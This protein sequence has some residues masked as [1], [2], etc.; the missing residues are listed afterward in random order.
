MAQSKRITLRR[1]IYLNIYAYLLLIMGIGIV[2]IPLYE[3]F[4]PLLIIQ[5]I[6]ASQLLKAAIRIFRQWPQKRRSY[7]L[8]MRQNRK[9]FRPET[10]KK[11]MKAPCGRILV[12]TVLSDLDE[13]Q[14]YKELKKRYSIPLSHYLRRTTVSIKPQSTII[15]ING[16]AMELHREKSHKKQTEGE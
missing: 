15:R 12:K 1:Y 7:Y 6:I 9:E 11:H 2:F 13:N 4:K 5:I 14:R 8:L 3:I 16:E 10:F